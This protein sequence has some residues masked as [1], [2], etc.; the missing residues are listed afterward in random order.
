MPE[1]RYGVHGEVTNFLIKIFIHLFMGEGASDG[2]RTT[3]QEWVPPFHHVDPGNQIQVVWLGSKS[4][5]LLSHLPGPRN[6]A[7]SLVLLIS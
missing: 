5:Y 6:M 7:F 2:Q 4:L 1:E 3:W